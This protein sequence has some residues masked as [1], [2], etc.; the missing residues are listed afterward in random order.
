MREKTISII[1]SIAQY[2]EIIVSIIIL[3][4]IAVMAIELINDVKNIVTNLFTNTINIHY[5]EFLS[6]ALKLV[7]GIEF[8]RML[9]THSSDYVLEVL[10]LAS[11]R[12]LIIVEHST[13]WDI[14][15]SIVAI[16]ILFAVR[17]YL[18]VKNKEKKVKNNPS[19]LA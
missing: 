1:K 17:K 2:L 18:V 12:K 9:I 8:L 15:I 6:D 5:D 19:S 14:L 4:G 10:I 7:I 3:A 13:S 16:A 11:A